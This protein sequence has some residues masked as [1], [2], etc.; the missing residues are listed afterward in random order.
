M[1][2]CVRRRQRAAIFPFLFA[3]GITLASAMIE[4]NLGTSFRERSQLFFALMFF[5]VVAVEWL[6]KRRNQRLDSRRAAH[7]GSAP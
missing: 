5:A 3:I 6:V 4:G 2:I 1:A 7:L